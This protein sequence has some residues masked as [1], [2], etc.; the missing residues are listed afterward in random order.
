M[1]FALQLSRFFSRAG[2]PA[3][4]AVDNPEQTARQAAQQLEP[5][6][7]D[8]Q[9]AL[10]EFGRCSSD[11]F[12]QIAEGLSALHGRLGDVRTQAIDLDNILQE[13]DGDRALTSAFDLF[14]KS[15]DLAH[16]SIGIAL[17][18]EEQ[19]ELMEEKLLQNRNRF[20]KNS[21]MFRVL[22]MNIRAEAA[23]I[24]TS[25]R[26][27]FV[28]VAGE[29][30]SMERQM[31]ASVETAFAKLESIVREATLG[32][33]QLQ[34]LK[35]N[36]QN[37]ARRSITLLR[38]ELDTVKNGLAPC[39]Q[40]SKEITR[41]LAT[42][43][44]QTG[45]LITSL[46]YQDI[47]SQQLAHVGQGFADIATDLS[48]DDSASAPDLSYLHHAARVQK[49]HLGVSRRAIQDAS[50]RIGGASR[51]LLET[52][53]A[54][55]TCFTTM[56]RTADAVFRESQVS[57]KF[58][59][60]TDTLVSISGQSE[61]TSDRIAQLLDRIEECVRVFSTEIRHHELEVQLV[62]LNA[63]IAAARMPDARA[64]NKLAEET[65]QLSHNAADLTRMMREQLSEALTHLNGMR[66]EADE[67]KT[68]I[69]RE[70][71]EL[72]GG[73]IVVSAK[74]ARLNDRI[75]RSSGEASRQFDVAYRQVSE[76]LRALQFPQLI[77]TSFDP[78]EA[79]CENLL[80]ATADFAH[81]PISE[82][83]AQRIAVHES[84]YTMKEER[85]AHSAAIAVTAPAAVAPAAAIT[86]IELFDDEPA[87]VAAPAITR[88][89]SSALKPEPAGTTAAPAPAAAAAPA[90]ATVSAASDDLGAGVELF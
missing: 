25:D 9:Q 76:L 51:A 26:S 38:T 40:G 19:M 66:K 15:I 31:S 7:A 4:I 29:M 33:A 83:G 16:A 55:V 20:A 90:L 10:V 35:E 8:A 22:V 63:Q 54:L 44:T 77:A 57:Q 41:L 75:H 82:A 39:L 78:A 37:N 21:L 56:E 36:L 62:A 85:E 12:T 87:P 11:E 81:G 18:Q 60:E 49:N 53:T 30:D 2:T 86:A 46:Q 52:G 45:A 68:T 89:V 69:G 6:V 73:S 3:R 67:V 27:V 48:P 64:L 74:L 58:K 32:R 59:T 42:A 5:D 50:D 65:A 14:R 61:I 79:L 70:K 17:S 1:A 23:R 24:P 34:S 28:A 84:R 71:S 13:N 47:V 43:R 72:A 80:A 88:T